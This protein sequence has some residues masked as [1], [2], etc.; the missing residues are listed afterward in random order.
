MARG[1]IFTGWFDK[2]KQ[3]KEWTGDF[4]I[5]LHKPPMTWDAARSVKH[6]KTGKPYLRIGMRGER[7]LSRETHLRFRYR[8]TGLGPLRV[9]IRNRTSGKSQSRS[10]VDLIT[11]AWAETTLKFEFSPSREGVLPT[12]D[13]LFFFADDGTE[14]LIDDVLLFEPGSR[15][16]KSATGK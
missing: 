8:L 15:K 4:E 11:G 6:P 2:G 13:E 1:V 5:V 16:A 7:T 14:L 12:A 3:G 9:K 10:L